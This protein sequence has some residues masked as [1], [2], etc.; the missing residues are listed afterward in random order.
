MPLL[1]PLLEAWESSPGDGSESP[2]RLCVVLLNCANSS[3]VS[4]LVSEAE[5]R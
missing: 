2:M 5:D 4:T 1:G 3:F